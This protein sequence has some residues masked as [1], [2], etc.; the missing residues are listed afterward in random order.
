MVQQRVSPSRMWFCGN[1]S[2]LASLTRVFPRAQNCTAVSTFRSHFASCFLLWGP[3]HCATQTL[4][5]SG[6]LGLYAGLPPWLTF[7][8]SGMI[9]MCGIF[10]SPHCGLCF[11][12]VFHRNHDSDLRNGVEQYLRVLRHSVSR[13]LLFGG[14]TKKSVACPTIFG[15]R[16]FCEHPATKFAQKAPPS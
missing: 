3:L 12:V 1:Y 2:S 5:H 14:V 8:L 15:P 7:A 10:T 11:S 13:F 6:P 9:T 16:K 4:R